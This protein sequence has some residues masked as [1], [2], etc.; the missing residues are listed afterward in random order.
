LCLKCHGKALVLYKLATLR[1]GLS[2]CLFV[3]QRRLMELIFL[4][5]A[6]TSST[7]AFQ[8]SI[9]PAHLAHSNKHRPLLIKSRKE[10]EDH[11]NSFHGGEIRPTPFHLLSKAM[12][13][14]LVI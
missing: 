14:F 7:N 5:R 6:C 3:G 12:C 10:V 4:S 2:F 13:N 9:P 8:P 1:T 11:G